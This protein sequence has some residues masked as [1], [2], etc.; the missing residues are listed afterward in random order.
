MTGL[1]AQTSLVALLE[2]CS[3]MGEGLEE[4]PSP[5]GLSPD[6]PSR[7]FPSSP[8]PETQAPFIAKR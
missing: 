1:T 8:S 3:C 7:L 5:G 4:R 6:M 2:N